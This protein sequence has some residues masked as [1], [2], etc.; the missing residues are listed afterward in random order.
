ML[1]LSKLFLFLTKKAKYYYS[2]KTCSRKGKKTFT[3]GKAL[4]HSYEMI[5][6]PATAAKDGSIAKKCSRCHKKAKTTNI[7][8]ASKVSI[9]KKY[10]T[11]VYKGNNTETT[12]VTVKNRKN[13]TISK[14][15]YDLKFE[16]DYVNK[17][18]TAV[19]TFKGNY[20]GTITLKYKITGIPD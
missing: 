16:N 18:G 8:K 1:L 5:L 6:T 17:E 13:K 4:G 9:P 19:I 12:T 11:V 20:S 3:A 7:Y 15:Y 2:C 14:A 10:Q